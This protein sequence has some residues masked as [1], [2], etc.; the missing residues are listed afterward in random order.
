[1]VLNGGGIIDVPRPMQLTLTRR[2]SQTHQ[3]MMHDKKLEPPGFSSVAPEGPCQ[4][5]PTV[6]SPTQERIAS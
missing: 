6:S 2:L 4:A 5:Q 1:L 3:I